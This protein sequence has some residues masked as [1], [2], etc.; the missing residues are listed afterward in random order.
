MGLSKKI[1]EIHEDLTYRPVMATTL[2]NFHQLVIELAE[3]KFADAV[4]YAAE[5]EWALTD[6][7]VQDMV[8][9]GVE[10]LRAIGCNE[11][12]IYTKITEEFSGYHYDDENFKELWNAINTSS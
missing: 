10:Y 2:K 3:D 6:G 12:Y 8:T 5:G 7:T 9:E 4:H 1:K 11:L